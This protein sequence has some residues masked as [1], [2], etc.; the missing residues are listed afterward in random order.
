MPIFAICIQCSFGGPSTAIRE[1]KEIK[2]TQVANQDVKPSLFGDDKVLYIDNPKDI[3]KKL[4][5]LI[6][7]FSKLA[8][9]KISVQT[10]VAFLYTNNEVSEIEIKE[11]VTLNIAFKRVKYRG[12][13]L[14]ENAQN[15]CSE[16]CKT[17]MRKKLKTTQSGEKIYCFLGLEESKLVND[18][19]TYSSLQSQYNPYQITNSIFHKNGTNNFEI[20]M[21]T[22][23]T[24]NGQ[25]NFE[26]EE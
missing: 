24:L 3:T 4:L 2:G 13:N 18:R 12:V 8:G 6:H 9:Y 26:K 5:E 1:Y 21:E 17:L 25:N 11:I 10:S 7:E 23:K 20:C 15:L 14:P 22:Q 16:N 19:F